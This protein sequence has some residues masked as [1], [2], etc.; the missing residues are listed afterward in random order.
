M[1]ICFTGQ[2]KK[3]S[4]KIKIDKDVKITKKALLENYRKLMPPFELLPQTK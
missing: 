3:G 2:L 4:D 1:Q